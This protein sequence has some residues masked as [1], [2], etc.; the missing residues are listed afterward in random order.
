MIIA[1]LYNENCQF[2]FKYSD[3][4]EKKSIC[5]TDS[6]NTK[7]QN[8]EDNIFDIDPETLAKWT[9]F[10]E[11][12]DYENNI[13]TAIDGT[14]VDLGNTYDGKELVLYAPICDS[15]D[16][17]YKKINCL[18]ADCCQNNNTYFEWLNDC[19]E[20]MK[21]EV[22][23]SGKTEIVDKDDAGCG[24]LNFNLR[25]LKRPVIQKSDEYIENP[26]IVYKI[27]DRVV[28][29]ECPTDCYTVPIWSDNAKTRYCINSNK[30]KILFT[31]L[32]DIPSFTLIW[33]NHP[34][35]INVN[36]KKEEIVEIENGKL[37]RNGVLF[38]D[39]KTLG[40][41]VGGNT[42]SNGLDCI[43]IQ[44]NGLAGLIGV[45]YWNDVKRCEEAIWGI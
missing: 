29:S 45:I 24:W 5:E 31:A 19:N 25:E 15:C 20:W 3:P 34:Y 17:W 35:T 4:D 11:G 10:Y 12:D 41:P 36:M 26:T 22:Q 21:V 13:E 18:F 44:T 1:K 7:C 27:E 40:I 37:Y 42:T 8:L 33:N 32:D 14:E 23:F 2:F 6:P 16:C 43:A 38:I 28:C 9:G 30:D 39:L